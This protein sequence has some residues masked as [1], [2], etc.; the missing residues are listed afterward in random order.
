[1]SEDVHIKLYKAE[2]ARLDELYV[3]LEV[4]WDQVPRYFLVGLACPFI[5]YFKGFGWFVTSILVTLALVGCQSYLVKMRKSEN[6]WTR[7]R[8]EEDIARREAE[9][10]AGAPI[11]H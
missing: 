3:H 1:M 2:I 7:A 8:L 9:L 4:L 6:R 10:A 11:K 5:L